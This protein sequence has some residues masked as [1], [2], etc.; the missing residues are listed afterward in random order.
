MTDKSYRI[1]RARLA[2]RILEEKQAQEIWESAQQ[3]QELY[4][5][6]TRLRLPR[7]QYLGP[8]V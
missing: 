5:R 3:I 7:D 4:L 8:C 1:E 2:F 6:F